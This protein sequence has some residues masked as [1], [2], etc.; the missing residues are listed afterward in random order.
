MSE[1]WRNVELGELCDIA[2]GGTPARKTSRFW[3][4]ERK[5]G[6]VWLSI[7]D[8]PKDAFSWVSESKEYLSNEGA[9]KVQLVRQGTL[10][11]SFKLSIGRVCF[12]GRDLRTNEAIAA[13]SIKEHAGVDKRYLAWFLWGQDWNAIAANDEKLK[14][15]TLNKEKL[16]KV[17]INLPSLPEQ[18]RIVS[19]LDEAFA[20][21]GTAIANTENN[22]G[23]AREL[24]DGYL[25]KIFSQR[26]GVHRKTLDEICE[27]ARGG[28]PRPIREFL[29]DDPDGL[30]WI[31]ISDATASSKYIYKTAQ[32]IKPEGAKRSRMVRDGDF[33]LSNSMSFGR[34]YIMRTS[35][36]IHDGWLVLR[37]KS[38][39]Y[40]QE[41]L[42]Y[43]LSSEEAYEQFNIRASGTTVRNLNIDLVRSVEVP[44]PP[45]SEQKRV[46]SE[47]GT[48]LE[49]IERI[50]RIY[51]RKI[52]ALNELKEA[53]LN[54]AFAGELTL[55]Q[56]EAEVREAMA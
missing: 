41:Y 45:I 1:A 32:K 48:L 16:K 23:N 31:K 28:S 56:Q 26:E 39:L 5:S 15:K 9:D 51:E 30:N 25:K 34:P 37:D 14:G 8:I 17:R 19:I 38:E 12:A 6:N 18:K 36:C 11:F 20:G 22:I 44:L 33:I 24:F 7:A 50:E 46:A 49:E 53:L 52:G 13:L 21:I 10:L 35:G 54:K 47:I 2:L 40:E 29:T 55:E 27:I 4:V 3:D 43:F 42:Y